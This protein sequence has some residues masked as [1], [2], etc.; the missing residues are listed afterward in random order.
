M[1]VG[2]NKPLEPPLTVN[3]QMR[4]SKQNR[5]TKTMGKIIAA[6]LLEM[7][8]NGAKGTEC[9][10]H[11]GVSNTAIS[12]AL[13]RLRPPAMPPAMDKLTEKQR[14][15]AIRRSEGVPRVDAAQEVFQCSRDSARVLGHRL[16]H[17]PDVS[18]SIS[19]LLHTAG[20]G[21]RRRMER[22]ADII[23]HSP[24]GSEAVR[25]IELASRMTNDLGGDV[26]IN[27]L[28]VDIRKLIASIPDNAAE[29]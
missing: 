22:L 2:K 16:D 28:D 17:D 8:N 27:I 18:V 13:K 21:K 11:F 19:S 12:K 15:Y 24:S 14:Q 4:Y 3:R 5:E 20:A 10:L 6:E 9:A 29:T 7:V 25:A 26:Q 1:S 23:V